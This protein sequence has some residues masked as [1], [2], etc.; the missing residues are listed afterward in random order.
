M[1]E[2]INVKERLPQEDP[3]AYILF[4]D[5]TLT[6]FGRYFNGNSYKEE[7]LWKPENGW[8]HSS[9]NIKYWMP[10]PEAPK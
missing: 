6:L 9:A 4:T 7:C 2:W 10:L 3:D 5:G 1:S 8:V